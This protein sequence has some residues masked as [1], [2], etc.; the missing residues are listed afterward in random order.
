M[1]TWANDAAGNRHSTKRNR[2]ILGVRSFRIFSPSLGFSSQS[3][4]I[5]LIQHGSPEN[6]SQVPSGIVLKGNRS[7]LYASLT[8]E[9]RSSLKLW[10]GFGRQT[11]WPERM[12]Y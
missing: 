9:A 4:P 8:L 12:V 6:V 5:H 11:H 2:R 10:L 1:A 3:D 7:P